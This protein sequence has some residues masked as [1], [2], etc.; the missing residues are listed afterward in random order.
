MHRKN[1]I[2]IHI[3]ESIH[4]GASMRN[5]QRFFRNAALLAGVQL[6]LRFITVSF[7][8]YVSAKMG[9]EGMGLVTLVMSVYGLSV[10]VAASGVNLAAVRLSAR[11][12]SECEC[13]DFAHGSARLRRVMR[14]CI[15]YS[16]LFGIGAAGILF[17]ASEV[18]GI[19]LLGD[20][21]TI[22]SLRVLAVSLPAISLSSALAGYFT[23]VRRVYKNALVSVLEQFVKIALTASALLLFAPA[24][25]EYACLAVVGGAALAEGA[26]M[27]TAMLLYLRD[28]LRRRRGEPHSLPSAF[29]Q[30][31]H[32]AFPVAVGA[33]ARQGLVTAEHLAIPWGFRKNGASA[34]SALASYGVLHG[35]VYPLIFFPSAVLGA[36][37]GL[38]V[39][40]FTEFQARGERDKIRTIAEK[41]MGTSLLFAI[42]TAGIF[43]SF[44]YDL[45]TSLYPGTDAALQL[46]RIAPLIPVMYLD[47]AVDAML[48]GLGEQ[49]YCMR[50]NIADSLCCLL[51]VLLLIPRFGLAGYF[52]VQYTCELMNAALSISRLLQ[53]TDLRP[54]VGRWVIRPLLCVIFATSAVHFLSGF[55]SIPLIGAGGMCGAR[56][57]A[58]ILLYGFSLY[59]TKFYK[60]RKH[61]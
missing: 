17:S 30:V 36:F 51:L 21:R 25:I 19:H 53:V 41:V 42:G 45:G 9:A 48:K 3:T 43:L 20:T 28:S 22:P 27:I 61:P 49:V 38:L 7:N 58:A 34:S 37:A 23:G 59:L 14:G 8:T 13:E 32:T 54:R 31:F 47:S 55:P 4:R 5:G 16:L 35:M 56:I 29:S 39:P 60:Y 33:Y 57:A 44:A 18:I 6:F 15:A 50:V 52:F 2:A 26:S 12:L 1:A 11:A 40:E 24:G 46:A 10:T